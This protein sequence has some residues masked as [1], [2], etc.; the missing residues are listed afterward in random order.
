[1]GLHSTLRNE[2]L[3]RDILIGIFFSDKFEYFS[4]SI[5]KEFLFA[6]S[7]KSLD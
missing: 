7:V 3:L 1:M 5:G 4:F 2:K 6:L